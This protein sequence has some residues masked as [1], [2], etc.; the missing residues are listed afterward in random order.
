MNPKTWLSALAVL[1]MANASPVHRATTPSDP[2]L[3]LSMHGKSANRLSFKP[4][5]EAIQPLV[6]IGKPTVVIAFASWCVACIDEMPQTLADYARFKDRVNFLG[7]DYTENETTA[8]KLAAKYKLVF[9]IESYVVGSATA[10]PPPKAGDASHTLTLEAPGSKLTPELMAA[11]KKALPNDLYA[12][13]QEVERAQRSGSKS[14]VAAVEARTGI[15]I[16]DVLPNRAGSPETRQTTT[17]TLP[18]VFVISADGMVVAVFDGYESGDDRIV[19]ALAH[20]GIR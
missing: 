12:K 13:L 11:Y 19:R 6:R 4:L 9:P 10:P 8:R 3:L 5:G 20:L 17:M 1:L 15:T 16:E 2:G 18:H 14:N 7:I